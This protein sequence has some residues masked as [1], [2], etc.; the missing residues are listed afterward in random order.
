VT[1]GLSAPVNNFTSVAYSESEPVLCL[2]PKSLWY[3]FKE[4]AI[5]GCIISPA[6]MRLYKIIC[7]LLP[8]SKFSKK[9]GNATVKE[10]ILR[11]G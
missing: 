10:E 9:G 4:N 5:R 6:I 1:C 2:A 8:S 11:L 3:N 7:V